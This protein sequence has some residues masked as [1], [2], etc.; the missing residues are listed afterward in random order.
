MEFG[1]HGLNISPVMPR[2]KIREFKENC[3]IAQICKMM[4]R[5]AHVKTRPKQH[6]KTGLS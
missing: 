4:E 3:E 5:S 6:R 1:E 2:A